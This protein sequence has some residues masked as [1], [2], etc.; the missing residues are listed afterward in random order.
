MQMIKWTWQYIV[1]HRDLLTKYATV[2]LLSAVL[3]FS[4]LYIL[5]DLVGLHY[6]ASAT[7]SFVLAATSN[8]WFNKNWTFKSNGQH[9]KQLPVFFTLAILGLIINNNIMYIAVEQLN[10]HYLWAKL[11]AAAIV[12]FWNFFGNKYLTFRIK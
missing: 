6:L 3:D 8:Y 11:F 4:L 7:I 12:T 10:L 2:G 1:R 9:R 5:T